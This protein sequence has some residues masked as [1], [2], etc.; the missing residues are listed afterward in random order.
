MILCTQATKS[1]LVLRVLIP[2]IW[3][4]RHSA[5]CGQCGGFLNS[6]A[7]W[8]APHG[9]ET[10]PFLGFSYVLELKRSAPKT[11]SFLTGVAP[12]FAM[13]HEPISKPPFMNY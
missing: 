1:L 10:K 8:F 3:N 6:F 11:A 7:T 12:V 9:L 2:P 4:V 5:K 13:C